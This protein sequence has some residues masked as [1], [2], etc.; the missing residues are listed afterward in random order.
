VQL[1]QR[2]PYPVKCFNLLGDS[3]TATSTVFNLP[4]ASTPSE[5][6]TGCLKPI[7]PATFSLISVRLL[8]LLPAAHPYGLS[9][10]GH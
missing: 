9:A 7:E 3:Y 4:G 2:L 1:K 8:P 5:R 6:G 10:D